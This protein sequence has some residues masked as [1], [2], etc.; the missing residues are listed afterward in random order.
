MYSVCNRRQPKYRIYIAC[1][2]VYHYKALA[3]YEPMKKV[4]IQDWGRIIRENNIYACQ[5]PLMPGSGR[6][7]GL[8]EPGFNSGEIKRKN[9]GRRKCGEDT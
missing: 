8:P 4:E 2:V 6:I 7:F 1:E 3:H 5:E 9:E